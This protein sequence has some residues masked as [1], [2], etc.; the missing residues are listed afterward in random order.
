[1]SSNDNADVVPVD[2]IAR[3]LGVKKRMVYEHAERG[4]IPHRR[5]GRRI[6]FPRIAIEEWFAGRGTAA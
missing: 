3:R 4:R 1:V 6:I 2:E 5:L